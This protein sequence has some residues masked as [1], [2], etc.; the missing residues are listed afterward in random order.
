MQIY[1]IKN[2]GNKT[3]EETVHVILLHTDHLS[4][5]YINTKVVYRIQKVICE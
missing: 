4:G 5:T 1:A 2:C 3:I